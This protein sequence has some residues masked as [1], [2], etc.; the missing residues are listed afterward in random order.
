MQPDKIR[1]MRFRKLRFGWSAFWALACVL[2]IVLWV[3]SYWRWEML[4]K[5]WGARPAQVILAESHAGAFTF[6]YCD[7]RADPTL[8]FVRWKL[9]ILPSSGDKF[10][11]IGGLDEAYAGFLFQRLTDGFFLSLPYWFLVPVSAMCGWLPWLPWTRR[12]GLRTLLIATTLVAVV[13]GLAVYT[14]K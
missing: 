4:A 7:A 6:H 3:R 9:T 1:G 13:L 10:F 8:T 5:G 12:F 2:L 14:M 11:P